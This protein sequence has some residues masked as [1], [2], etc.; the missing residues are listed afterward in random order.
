MIVIDLSKQKAPDV[1]PRTIQQ[2]IFTG[3]LAP[4]RDA[5]IFLYLWRKKKCFGLFTGNCKSFVG[6]LYNT[7]VWFNIIQFKMI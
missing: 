4:A 6:L 1:D 7:L 2:I 3:N 5:T